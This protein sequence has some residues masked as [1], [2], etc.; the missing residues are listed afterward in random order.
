VDMAAKEHR[1]TLDAGGRRFGLVASRF[2][3]IVSKRLVEGAMDCILRHGGSESNIEVFWVHGSFEI[4]FL[5]QS[6]ARS[7]RWDALICLGAVVRGET[8]HF[9]YIAGEAARGIARVGLDTGVP[10]VFGVLTTDTLEQ[11]MDRAGAKGGN[12]G[13][14]SALSAIEMINLIGVASGGGRKRGGQKAR[15]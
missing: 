2:N 1:V 14:D 15:S 12:K 8:P 9:D 10:V 6:L 3:E 5:A 11:A 4:P 13:W 7:G